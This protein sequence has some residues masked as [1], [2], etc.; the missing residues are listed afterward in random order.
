MP[1]AALA[2]VLLS[3]VLAVGG[4]ACGAPHGAGEPP[5]AALPAPP[6]VAPAAPPA[7]LA[8]ASAPGCRITVVRLLD[9]APPECTFFVRVNGEPFLF[10][11][12]DAVACAE[13]AVA[14]RA[15]ARVRAITADCVRRDVAA[16]HPVRGQS[17]P[18]TAPA[19]LLE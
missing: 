10:A 4:A 15:L 17:S 6:L 8:S 12:E 3:S 19:R 9:A 5:P 13:A 18:A 16:L 1:R 14:R 7:P 2:A 11:H